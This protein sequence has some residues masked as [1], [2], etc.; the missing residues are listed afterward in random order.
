MTTFPDYVY[1]YTDYTVGPQYPDS[2]N[3]THAD[4]I[5]QEYSF[6]IVLLVLRCATAVLGVAGNGATVAT[7]ARHREL[8]KPTYL[9]ICNACVYDFLYGAVVA[10]VY[11]ATRDVLVTSGAVRFACL[12]KGVASVVVTVGE[13][14]AMFFIALDRLVYIKMPLHYFSL[15]T[16]RLVLGAITGGATLTI[17]FSIG[18]CFFL[19]A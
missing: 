4:T 12:V 10:P 3:I 7:V 11:L 6:S 15:V 16:T 9:L 18:E 19:S 14:L 1:T 13:A 17:L 2:E 5:P 8:W